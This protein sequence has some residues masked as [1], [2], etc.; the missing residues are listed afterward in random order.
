MQPAAQQQTMCAQCTCPQMCRAQVRLAVNAGMAH[1]K[2]RLLLLVCQGMHVVLHCFV[3]SPMPPAQGV[4]KVQQSNQCLTHAKLLLLLPNSGHA[5]LCLQPKS[6]VVM[7][8]HV[9]WPAHTHM[10]ML[11]GSLSLS[12]LSSHIHLC[13][14]N[15]YNT[16]G[17][18]HLHMIKPCTC[19]V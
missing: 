11:P 8:P 19:L 3:L 12:L 16:A 17:H 13:S 1:M 14:R 15:T 2:L 18:A 9:Y 7:Q 10:H 4:G 5:G 6:Y